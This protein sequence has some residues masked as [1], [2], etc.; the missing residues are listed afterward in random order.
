[1][2]AVCEG[3]EYYILGKGKDK[4]KPGIELGKLGPSDEICPKF[5]S[6]TTEVKCFFR[7]NK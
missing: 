1:M 6:K 2:S 3:M 5:W 7:A 4:N